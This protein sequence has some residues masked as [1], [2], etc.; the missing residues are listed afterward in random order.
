MRAMKSQEQA[1]QEA[2]KRK[3]QWGK[4]LPP[5][6]LEDIED[7]RLI[8]RKWGPCPKIELLKKP[9]VSLTDLLLADRGVE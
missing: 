6:L 2:P 5:Q 1:I 4:P 9:G 7:G 8:V 3:Q